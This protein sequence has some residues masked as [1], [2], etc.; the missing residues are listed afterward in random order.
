M[1]EAGRLASSFTER[2]V[3]ISSHRVAQL[4]SI[5]PRTARSVSEY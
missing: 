4:L 3:L 1:H 2:D 5:D